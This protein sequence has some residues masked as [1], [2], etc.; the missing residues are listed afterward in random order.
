MQSSVLPAACSPLAFSTRASMSPLVFSL[1]AI[2]VAWASAIFIRLIW[3]RSSAANTGEANIAADTNRPANAVR[4]IGS[5]SLCTVRP[6]GSGLGYM[7]QSLGLK[8][9]DYSHA[10]EFCL[11]FASI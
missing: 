8:P 5:S 1:V 2:R 11:R 3:Q 9:I 6:G 4:F 7:P 10:L